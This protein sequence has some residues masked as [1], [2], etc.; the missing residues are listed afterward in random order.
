[1]RCRLVFLIGLLLIINNAFAQWHYTI[2]SQ[3]FYGGCSSISATINVTVYEQGAQVHAAQTYNS[4]AECE[5]VR[6]EWGM[7]NYSSGG[8]YA[9]VTSSPCQ[10][11]TGSNGNTGIYY[12]EQ[13]LYNSLGTEGYTFSP[14]EQDINQNTYEEYI[15]RQQAFGY[16]SGNAQNVNPNIMS[17][18]TGDDE[19]DDSYMTQVRQLMNERNT[20]S[21]QSSPYNMVPR[22]RDRVT[23]TDYEILDND[24]LR[25]VIDP[26]KI[27]LEQR[28][29]YFAEAQ[30]RHRDQM[31]G[32]NVQVA[33]ENKMFNKVGEQLLDYTVKSFNVTQAVN[34]DVVE[35]NELL[36]NLGLYPI[37]GESAEQ[38]KIF[39]DIMTDGVGI[40]GSLL[41]GDNMGLL[42]QIGSV[43]DK[44]LTSTIDF[45]EGAS[46]LVSNSFNTIK[47]VFSVGTFVKEQVIGT[48]EKAKKMMI[49][50][51]NGVNPRYIFNEG[52]KHA[53]AVEYEARIK[54]YQMVTN[55]N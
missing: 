29:R 10:G 49:D 9:R 45:T 30:A 32:E 15:M 23:L 34:E 50:G 2:T 11:N 5:Q 39:T 1:M 27:R 54:T 14:T 21:Y 51:V 16:N 38:L 24:G 42:T 55:K 18:K 26:E 47:R 4:Q 7:I 13:S 53:K 3:S 37:A 36:K 52:E 48:W 6:R 19:F 20:G 31:D 22:I 17:A 35:I 12:G 40:S 25:V 44:L 41:E 46:A 43:T 28:D 33:A 8:C